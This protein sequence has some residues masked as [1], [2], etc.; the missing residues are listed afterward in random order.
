VA[1]A[2]LGLGFGVGHAGAETEGPA[3][4]APVYVVQP[5]DTLWAIAGRLAPEV[6]A[7]RAVAALRKAAGGAALTPGQRIV[8]PS[9][10]R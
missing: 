4:A 3:P 2:A 5:G 7:Q 6:D 10:L 1:G 8:V 9:A